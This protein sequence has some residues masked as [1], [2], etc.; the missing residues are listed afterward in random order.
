MNCVSARS[1]RS[2]TIVVSIANLRVVAVHGMN[3]ASGW[4]RILWVAK[5]RKLHRGGCHH[6]PGH[7]PWPWHVRAI[8][9]R[10]EVARRRDRPHRAGNAA[11]QPARLAAALATLAEAAL[12]ERSR[13]GQERL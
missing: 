8:R 4:F 1:A 7:F 10:R 13:P 5:S 2:V 3:R 6:L 11:H 9:V 12:G